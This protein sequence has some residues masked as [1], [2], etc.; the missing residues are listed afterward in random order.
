MDLTDSAFLASTSIY[1]PMV[2]VYVYAQFC[3]WGINV[4]LSPV[5]IIWGALT[6]VPP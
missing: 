5:M 1:P 3:S 2:F 4:Y 6:A